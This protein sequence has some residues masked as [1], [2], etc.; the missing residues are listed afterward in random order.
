MT[1]NYSNKKNIL[2]T[3]ADLDKAVEQVKDENCC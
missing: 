1:R 3:K 2:H